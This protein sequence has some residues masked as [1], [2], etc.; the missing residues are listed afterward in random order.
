[1][2]YG[3][4]VLISNSLSIFSE[5][6]PEPS[7]KEKKKAK[8]SAAQD[9][10]DAESHSD[11]DT[12]DVPVA[13]NL[14]KRVKGPKK[15]LFPIMYKE[16][17][18]KCLQ[19]C[20]AVLKTHIEKSGNTTTEQITGASENG[21]AGPDNTGMTQNGGATKE[22]VN[23]GTEVLE[24]PNGLGSGDGAKAAEECTFHKIFGS[25]NEVNELLDAE[26]KY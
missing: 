3:S 25:I 24:V 17:S 4:W 7:K 5:P 15:F 26:R 9:A 12:Q 1:M 16:L 2:F 13:A 14:D 19:L 6:K 21:D 8:E 22:E 18:Q 20:K 23:G 11:S 10:K